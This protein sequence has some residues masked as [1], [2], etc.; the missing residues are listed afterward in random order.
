[1]LASAENQIHVVANL[2]ADLICPVRHSVLAE[3]RD[4]AGIAENARALSPRKRVR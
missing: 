2:S 1:M 3:A 4:V